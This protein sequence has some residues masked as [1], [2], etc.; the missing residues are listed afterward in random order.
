MSILNEARMNSE[1]FIDFLYE[2]FKQ[3]F[4]SK[5]RIY[6]EVAHKDFIA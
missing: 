1:I 3:V 6:R 4:D 5:P 2:N